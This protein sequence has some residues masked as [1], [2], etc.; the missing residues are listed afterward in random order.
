MTS[1]DR[2]PSGKKYAVGYGKPPAH[3]RFRKGVSGN[4]GGRPR[5]ITPKRT[6]QLALKEAYRIVTVREGDR[7]LRL[8]AIQAVLRQQIALA[9]KGNGPAQRAIIETVQTLER[10]LAAQAVTHVEPRPLQTMSETEV[11]RRLAF[12]MELYARGEFKKKPPSQKD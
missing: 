4:R 5:G 10:E 11:A 8:P 1:K 2:P 9:A 12:V 3:S 6:R 7:V